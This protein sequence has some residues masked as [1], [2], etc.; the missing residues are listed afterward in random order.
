[1]EC[2][3]DQRLF[4]FFKKIF[5]VEKKEIPLLNIITLDLDCYKLLLELKHFRYIRSSFFQTNQEFRQFNDFQLINFHNYTFLIFLNFPTP[6]NI[7][8]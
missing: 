5:F 8:L 3:L 4:I 2:P 6:T 7:F 1:M